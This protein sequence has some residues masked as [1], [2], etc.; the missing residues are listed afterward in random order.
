[1]GLPFPEDARL[2]GEPIYLDYNAT[3]P[4]AREVLDAVRVALLD[5]WGNP[6]STHVYGARARAA[7]EGARGQVAALLGCRPDDIVFTSGGTESDNAALI[8][9]AEALEKR[10]RHLVI[11]A[12]EHPAVEE[13]A[14]YLEGRGWSVDRIGVDRDGRAVPAEIEAAL[15]PGTTLVS[16]MHANNETGVVQPVREVVA[17]CRPRGIPVH[18]DAAQ[19]VGKIPA[20]PDEL[21]VD[22]LTVAGH[23][24]Y[25][26]KGIGALYIRRGTP[27]AA[28]LKGAGH[29]AGRRP[30]TENI[31]GIVGLGAAC[32][33]AS[34]EMGDRAA[35][36][37]ATRD[38]LEAALRARFPGLVTH[39]ARTERL[40]N[41]LS[42]AIPGVDGNELLARLD[43]VA[44]SAGAACHSGATEPSRVLLAMGVE[45]GVARCTLR[46]STGRATTLEEVD[47]AAERI[48]AAAGE[49]NGVRA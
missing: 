11:S 49:I 15:R 38:R 23:K 12:I 35:R 10:G 6:S 8:G 34:R 1:M 42:A 3:T 40:P 24:L 16:L 45:P 9:V 22:L 2:R 43:G 4:V 28:F 20:R 30:G 14:R 44:A 17:L 27:F 19:S 41:T 33:L 47:L 18:T 46:L 26:P 39:G 32:A 21:G 13:A 31:P 48:G 25:A 29:E 36:M 5:A 37:A 7:V